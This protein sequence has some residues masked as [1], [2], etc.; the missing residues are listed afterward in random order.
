[1]QDSQIIDLYWQRNEA[2]ISESSAKYGN[3]C[4][5]IANNILA[6]NEDSEECVNDTWLRAWN[7]IPPDRPN[8]LKH[9]LGRLTRWISLNRLRYND[10]IKRGGKALTLALDELSDTFDRRADVETKIELKELSQCIN[11]YLKSIDNT[12]RE[13]FLARYWYMASISEICRCFGF[14]ESKVKNMLM[15]TRKDLLK[16]LKEDGLC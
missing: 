11:A 9:Y 2:A 1:M 3:Y 13:V 5:V 6:D 4:Y 16:K 14:S 10:T 15:R 12:K 7:S 8:I